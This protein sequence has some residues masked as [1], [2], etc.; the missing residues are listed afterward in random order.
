[1]DNDS[2]EDFESLLTTNQDSVSKLSMDQ[3][4]H[5]LPSVTVKAKRRT[6]EQD[7]FHN[8]STSIAYYD[9]ASEIDDIY[10]RGDYMGD[11]I[12]QLLKRLDKNFVISRLVSKN[13]DDFHEYEEYAYYKGKEVLFV[14][15]YKPTRMDFS[16]ELNYRIIT[17][18]AIKSL[19]INE[20]VL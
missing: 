4:T 11:D 17:L 7:I 19:Y 8:R 12:F 20:K 10:D 5:N 14:V 15:N 16:G 3:K 6:Q 18:S 9:V 13:S 2:E 1:M